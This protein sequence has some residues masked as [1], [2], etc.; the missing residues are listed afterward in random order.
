[1]KVERTVVAMQNGPI[2]AMLLDY[3]RSLKTRP[4]YDHKTSSPSWGICRGIQ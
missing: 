3:W 2:I 1:M 4:R